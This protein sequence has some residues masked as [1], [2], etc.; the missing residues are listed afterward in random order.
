MEHDNEHP[1]QAIFDAGMAAHNAPECFRAPVKVPFRRNAPGR[2]S[3]AFDHADGD[4]AREEAVGGWV[5]FG[6]IVT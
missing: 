5:G 1:M 4:E 6:L 2:R 3:V